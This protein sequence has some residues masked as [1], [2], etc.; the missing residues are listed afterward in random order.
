MCFYN[1]W[2]KIVLVIMFWN[3]ESKVNGPIWLT[4]LTTLKLCLNLSY[5]L[6]FYYADNTVCRLYIQFC[7][8]EQFTMGQIPLW[9]SI[10]FLL[11]VS[12]F[13]HS[14]HID[15]SEGFLVT[16]T[17]GLTKKERFIK[18]ISMDFSK[19]VALC[20][21]SQS[22]CCFVYWYVH[23]II[24]WKLKK[25]VVKMHLGGKYLVFVSCRS[26]KMRG[27]SILSLY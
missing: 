7:V 3:L 27:F 14:N 26:V 21:I 6:E 5:G 17:M 25:C 20:C 22:Q 24:R 11:L 10:F 13:S 2:F 23:Q 15:D 19:S 16:L 9:R 8:K 1:E 18:G 4:F 12:P